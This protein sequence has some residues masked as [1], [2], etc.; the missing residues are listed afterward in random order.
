MQ[1]ECVFFGPLRDAVDAKSIVHDTDAETAGELLREL[2]AAY[3]NLRELVSGDELADGIA[4]TLNKR[5]L[6]NLD[7]LETEIENKDVLRLT[8]AVYGG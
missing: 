2:E 8:T 6:P 3:P 7:G 5:H 4:V 1:I